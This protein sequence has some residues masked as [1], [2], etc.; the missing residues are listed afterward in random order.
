M[1]DEQAESIMYTGL[2]PGMTPEQ[3]MGFDVPRQWANGVQITATPEST[4]IVFREQIGAV[5]GEGK[6]PRVMI[7]NVSSIVIPTPVALQL[8]DILK[9][10][11]ALV[12]PQEDGIGDATP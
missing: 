10:Q 9:S 5:E 7:R 8:A 3:S 4:F 12:M 2:L 6:E 11:I 1:T